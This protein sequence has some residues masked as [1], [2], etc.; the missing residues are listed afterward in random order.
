MSRVLIVGG[1]GYIGSHNVKFFLEKGVEVV[2]FDNLC[3]GH[4]ENVD[5]RASFFK[6]D[7]MNVDDLNAVFEQYS[8][9]A[10]LH[11]AAFSQVGESVKNPVKYY[12]NNVVGT[13]NLLDTMI[14]HDV[15]RF[16]LSS[17]AA[18]YGE[19]KEIPITEQC[20]TEPV[21]PY[22]KTKLVIE[23]I[24]KDFEAA[25]GLHYVSLRYFNACGAEYGIGEWHDPESHLIPLVLQTA[26]GE[27]SSISVFGTDYP[28]RDG[29][30]VRDYIHIV[31]LASA[32]YM[33]VEHLLSHAES[34][35]YNLG[36][37]NGFTVKEIIDTCK[38]IT[39]VDFKVEYGPRREGDPATLI[40]SHDKIKKDWGWTPKYDLHMI[41]SGAFEWHKK[42]KELKSS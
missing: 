8:F 25:Y 42:L 22:G 24:L 9:D 4:Q 23:G 10:V 36:S 1:A 19:P 11:F 34:R 18:T 5:S 16:V 35:L 32:H 14:K 6:G 21:N 30:C 17:T 38:E 20:P 29:T 26:L 31:D 27:R 40:A 3:L 33:A 7:L 15:K 12:Y 37:G 13:L 41:I 2:V 39:G 28:T